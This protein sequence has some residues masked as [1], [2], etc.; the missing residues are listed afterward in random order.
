LTV[1]WEQLFPNCLL[2]SAA[3]E[4]SDHCLLLLGLDDIKPG[5]PRFHFES[6]WPKIEGFMHTVEEAWNSVLGSSCPFDVLS[7]KL[8]STAR[9][10]QKL[11]PQSFFIYWKLLKTLGLC[12]TRKH[13]CT[14]IS[15]N[16]ALPSPLKRIARSRSRISWLGEGDAN[17]ALFHVHARNHRGKTLL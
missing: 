2:Q 9:K 4:D 11:E 1:E 7:R 10:L 12:P 16:I 3:S 5:K 13:G 6:F 14:I 15:R 17:T 8:K